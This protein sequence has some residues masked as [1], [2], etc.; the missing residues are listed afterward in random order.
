MRYPLISADLGK[1]KH[2]LDAAAAL[3]HGRGLRFA[4]VT[5]GVSADA[6][7]AALLAAG[8]DML[9]DSRVQNLARLPQDKPRMLLRIAM[10]SEAAEAVASAE[11]SLQSEVDTIARFGREAQRQEKRRRVLLMIDLGDLREGIPFFDTAAI[12]RA[13]QAVL[14][15]PALELY[16][17][18]ANLSCF[19]GVMAD[20]ENLGWL[21][22]IAERLRRTFDA[23]IPLVSGGNSSSLGLL[24]EGRM[25]AGVNHLRLGE[26]ILLG[27][28]TARCERMEGFCGD[29]FT[30]S[31]ELIEIQR[32]PSRP[33]GRIG[34]NAFGERTAFRDEGEQLRGILALGRQDTRAEGLTPLD[35]DVRVLGASSD[36]LIVDLSRT[37][38]GYRVGDI[39]SFTPDY[40][41]LL[42]AYTSP[43]VEKTWV[44]TAPEP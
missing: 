28:D 23:P 43:Y 14:R 21:V 17:L 29:V 37:K 44:N 31:A 3:C 10:P 1:L 24:A 41:A 16:G 27:N 13:A 42:G 35:A 39:L 5:K 40:G 30:L 4:A 20:E 6:R 25:P 9:A 8:A 2:N 22:A 33:I 18:G 26:S 15:E 7:I 34:A 19:G 38:K 12:E 11:I 36:H 32:K